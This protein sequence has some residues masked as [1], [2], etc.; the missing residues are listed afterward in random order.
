MA[1]HDRI[2][3]HTSRLWALFHSF[4]QLIFPERIIADRYTGFTRKTVSC[5]YLPWKGTEKHLPMSPSVQVDR[6]KG[7][8]WDTVIV[9]TPGAADPLKVDHVSK[10]KTRRFVETISKW[11]RGDGGNSAAPPSL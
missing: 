3:V 8:F 9:E 1:S 10:R 5:W 6:D 2:E 4:T 11:Q 7:G